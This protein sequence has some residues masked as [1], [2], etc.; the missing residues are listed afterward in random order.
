M[1]L[2]TRAAG[3]LH[4]LGMADNPAGS[5]YSID[6]PF[7]ARIT[8]NRLLNKPGSA[9]ETRH[10]VVALAGSGL[11]YTT[12]DSL[13]VFPTNRASEV[14][15]ILRRLGATGDEPVSPAMLKLSAPIP[16]REALSER[17]ALSKPARKI[18]ETLA[19]KTAS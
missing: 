2:A 14:E 11:R 4:C 8:E 10:L 19:A 15:E 13:G 6:H 5:A 1:Q 9:K 18:V 17:L 3:K 16:L 12:G 7:L